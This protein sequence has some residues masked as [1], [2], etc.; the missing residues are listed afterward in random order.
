MD[1]ILASGGES[2][3][4]KRGERGIARNIE[5]RDLNLKSNEI[6]RLPRI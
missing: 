2:S 6:G 3:R 4:Q 5:R 1:E